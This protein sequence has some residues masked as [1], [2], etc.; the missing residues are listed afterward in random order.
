MTDINNTQQTS[1]MSN[2]TNQSHNATGISMAHAEQMIMNNSD[3]VAIDVRPEEMY[4]Q[5]H[6][7]VAMSAPFDDAETFKTNL[8]GMDK[9]TSY[10][11]YCG[12]GETAQKAAN[13]MMEAGFNDVS[14]VKE[15][16]R[17]Y[18]RD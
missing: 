16:Y 1:S 2:V 17:S 9:D 11:I 10:I 5:D 13:M 3:I 18:Q 15:G 4:E 7:D 12:S 14:Y 8:E 6:M